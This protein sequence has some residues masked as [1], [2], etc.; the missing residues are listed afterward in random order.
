MLLRLSG[1]DVTLISVQCLLRNGGGVVNSS[2]NATV[3][4][5][6]IEL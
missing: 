5:E 1:Q 2:V 4:F 6:Q 3:S